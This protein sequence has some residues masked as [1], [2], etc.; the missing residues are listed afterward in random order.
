[1]LPV[2]AGYLGREASNKEGWISGL[3]D[4]LLKRQAENG[5]ELA[6]AFPAAD[7]LAGYRGELEAE[8]GKLFCFGF[9]EDVAHADE[10]APETEAQLAQVIKEFA[11][12]VIHCFGTEYGHTKAVLQAAPDKAKVLVGVQG[13]CTLCA[14]SYMASLPETVRKTVTFRDWLKKDSL[15]QQ[16]EKFAL[17]GAREEAAV[18]AAVHVTGRTDWDRYYIRKWNPDVIYHH[19]NETLRPEFYT[20][21]W[22]MAACEPYRIFVSQGDYPLKGLH[23]LLL[24]LG[25]LKEIFP[26]IRVCVAGNSLVETRNWKDRIKRSAYG[27]YLRK[28]IRKYDLED[29][30]EFAGRLTASEMKAQYLK[31][32]VFV[33]CSSVENSPNSLGEAMILG[34]PCVAADVGGVPSLFD[35][36]KDGILYRGSRT[37]G[38]EEHREEPQ[39]EK[40]RSVEEVADELKEALQKMFLNPDFSCACGE[41]AR[42]HAMH[43]HNR[44]LNYERMLAIYREIGGTP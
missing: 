33:C 5:I 1:M 39:P 40:E 17:R 22:E 37:P 10:D 7:Q 14:V 29:R 30:V 3:A 20:G 27:A 42:K 15:P 19:M 44:E 36:Q 13:L 8:G 28:L 6:V 23:F 18:R 41:S 24:A 21:K 31:A 35:G 38:A 25:E 43:T 12:D 2:I 4:S 26:G 16:Q 9:Y 11:P 32:N 34:V